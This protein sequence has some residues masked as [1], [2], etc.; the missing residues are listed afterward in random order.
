[1]KKMH[2]YSQKCKTDQK[3]MKLDVN[4]FPPCSSGVTIIN[5]SCAS[6]QISYA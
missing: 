3:N 5:H 4:L 6:S 1:M 2:L